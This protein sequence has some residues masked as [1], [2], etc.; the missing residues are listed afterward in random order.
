MLYWLSVPIVPK[1]Q[2]DTG[3]WQQHRTHW[4]PSSSVIVPPSEIW[5]IQ[6]SIVLFFTTRRFSQAAE[7]L[8]KRHLTSKTKKMIMMN[9]IFRIANWLEETYKLCLPHNG[10][11]SK[12][13]KSNSSLKKKKIDRIKFTARQSSKFCYLQMMFWSTLESHLI[14]N[15][16]SLKY[17]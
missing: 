6:N 12:N 15:E 3:W 9:K 1:P 7:A 5:V 14:I 4:N 13:E 8:S 2:A 16:C 10:Q 11:Q 17:Q